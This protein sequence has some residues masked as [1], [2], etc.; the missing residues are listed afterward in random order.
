MYAISFFFLGTLFL[1]FIG[2]DA[3][4]IVKMPFGLDMPVG[5]SYGEATVV[6]VDGVKML[7][8]PCGEV[9]L[10]AVSCWGLLHVL[11]WCLSGATSPGVMMPIP[12]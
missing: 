7:Q 5:E 4:D 6:L 10:L 11:Q 9:T 3:V 1:N 2:P 8:I 12:L